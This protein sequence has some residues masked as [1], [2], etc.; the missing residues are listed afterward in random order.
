MSVVS[1]QYAPVVGMVPA[2]TAIAELADRPN[3]RVTERFWIVGAP[4]SV[5]DMASATA[6]VREWIQE[7]KS[8]YICVTDVHSIM[9]S[10]WNPAL[11]RALK[12]ADLVIADGT[13]L[14]WTAWSRGVKSIG[15]VPGPDFM[16]ELCRLS[17][18]DWSH[19]LLGGAKGVPD[20]LAQTLTTLNPRLTICGTESPPFRPLTDDEDNE[21]IERIN[22]SKPNIVWIGLGCPKQEIWMSQHTGAIPGAIM[23]GV[24]AAFN[25]L[26]GNTPRAPLWM[27]NN[28][29]EWL[30]RL[31][32]EPRR[33]WRRYLVIAPIF[34]FLS[35][36]ETI[37]IRF[38]QSQ[39][40]K[41]L[42]HV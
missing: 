38:R 14:V 39:T 9:L 35:L 3:D 16:Q 34:V 29:L 2:G 22:A 19:F 42:H 7:K 17:P 6:I 33:L 4:V 15:R 13:P 1:D 20:R 11:S 28:G 36:F 5:V 40:P 41:K 10:R 27:R 21:L 24:G 37:A 18:G 30:H 32:T 12:G 8:R 23:I 25:F 31:V 26:S